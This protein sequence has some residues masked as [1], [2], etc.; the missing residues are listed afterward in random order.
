MSPYVTKK[1]HFAYK[2]FCWIK[3]AISLTMYNICMYNMF[4]STQLELYV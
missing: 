3:L 1:N 2:C 4:E